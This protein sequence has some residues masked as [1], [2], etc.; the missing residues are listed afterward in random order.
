M[1]RTTWWMLLSLLASACGPVPIVLE[2]DAGRPPAEPLLDAEPRVTTA[3]RAHFAGLKTRL[4]GG[5]SVTLEVERG[6]DGVERRR[7]VSVERDGTQWVIGEQGDERFH[8]FALHPSGELTLSLE[9]LQQPRDAF[10]LV[11]LSSTGV[12][13]ARRRLERPR[14][15][16]ASDF[17]DGRA[18]F[19]FAMK[20]V[21]RGSVITGW[22]PWVRLEANGEDLLI[23]LLS[24]LEN[25][26][27]EVRANEAVS[28]VMSLQWSDAQ[29]VERWSRMVDGVH[30]LIAVAW[31]YDDF[32][33]LDAATRLT[34]SRDASGRVVVGRTVSNSRCFALADVFH[35][36]TAQACRALRLGA[37]H[38]YQPFAF[39][40]FDA[41]GEREGTGFV[42][43]RALEDFVVF[44]V[45]T[46]WPKVALVGTAVRLNANGEPDTYQEPGDA[47]PLLPYDAFL[48]IVEGVGARELETHFLDHGRADAL[49]AVRW[50]DEGLYAVGIS[51]WNRW[52]GGMS[53]SR[54]A[55]PLLVERTEAGVLSSRVL[56]VGGGT[57]HAHLLSVVVSQG[58]LRATG[59]FDAPMTHSG[60]GQGPEPMSHG[61]LTVELWR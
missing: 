58:R 8:D 35:E 39:T 25:V 6:V 18:T 55:R 42:A 51:D 34:L 37:P 59:V 54:G 14:T 13:R 5:R 22:L 49:T 57:R 21:P 36:T 33:W 1:K 31:Q 40:V 11:R 2:P 16:P 61:A 19:P 20:G 46:R 43:P 38:R 10:E 50:V 23:A 48:S 56:A 30:V 24:L 41:H 17:A 32:L 60:D 52:W 12:E 29:W 3:P 28:A 53:V 47:T 9:H 26:D 15:I 27:G 4:Q 45:A 7:V 44:D